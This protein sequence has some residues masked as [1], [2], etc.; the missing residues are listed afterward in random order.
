[1]IAEDSNSAKPAKPEKKPKNKKKGQFMI[2]CDV[3]TVCM[4]LQCVC[5]YSVYV[6]T[7]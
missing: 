3:L 1:M 2:Q 7:V 6:L 4:C 5:A